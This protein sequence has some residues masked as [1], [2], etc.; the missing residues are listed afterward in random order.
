M[1]VSTTSLPDLL[2]LTPDVW[3]DERGSFREIWHEER[4]SS[5][6]LAGRMMQDNVSR[7]KTGVLRG[8]HF[9]WPRPQ[10][11]LV[12]VLSGSI[13][14]VVVDL[15]RGSSTF[16]KAESFELSAASARQLWVPE[17]FAHGFYVVEEAVVHYKC[18]D[19]YV[20]QHERTLFWRDVSTQV[21]WP[22]TDPIVS[23]KDSAAPPLVDIPE[24]ELPLLSGVA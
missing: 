10:G 18:T 24:H 7:S 20:P 22:R 11:K 19:F 12:T 1:N 3:R 2:L 4:Y 15:R 9:Q 23:P 14:D 16:G 6:G 17:G 8:L 13:L 21:E 5:A